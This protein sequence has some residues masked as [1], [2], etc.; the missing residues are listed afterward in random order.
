MYYAH[1]KIMVEYV[2]YLIMGCEIELTEDKKL[3]SLKILCLFYIVKG[4]LRKG[5]ILLAMKEPTKASSAY[6][7]AL[8]I[9]PNSEARTSSYLICK[10]RN[11]T[12]KS[13]DNTYHL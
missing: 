1:A 11:N 7:K 2:Q 9:D 12:M 6:Q 13:H 4:Y 3:L 10:A 8:E 5:S